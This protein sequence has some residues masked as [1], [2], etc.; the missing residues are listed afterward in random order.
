M[1]ERA[2]GRLKR[3]VTLPHIARY[4]AFPT[5]EPGAITLSGLGYHDYLLEYDPATMQATLFADGSQLITNW[6]GF[7]DTGE[8]RVVWGAG[9]TADTGQGN[10]A[11]MGLET[12]PFDADSIPL[13]SSALLLLLGLLL[14][15][16]IARR[17]R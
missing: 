4:C 6:F 3:S 9:S 7:P 12:G 10:Y 17:R 14:G 5:P 15:L 16:G 13:P 1:A 2:R 8:Q 11:Y